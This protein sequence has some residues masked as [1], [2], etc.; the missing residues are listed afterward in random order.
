MVVL[1]LLGR[2]HGP[3]GQDAAFGIT[4]KLFSQAA[5]AR[6]VSF[7]FTLKSHTSPDWS[8]WQTVI[9]LPEQESPAV[10]KVHISPTAPHCLPSATTS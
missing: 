10:Q 6:Q 9:G 5:G 8:V 1:G 2:N 4:H 7:G 3:S